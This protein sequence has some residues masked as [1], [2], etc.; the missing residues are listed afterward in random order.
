MYVCMY[1]CMYGNFSTA[2]RH[3]PE[4][5]ACLISLALWIAI[6]LLLQV[7]RFWPSNTLCLQWDM[8]CPTVSRLPLA[9][10][11]VDII[12]IY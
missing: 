4:N 1:V 8:T 5:K 9:V 7:T 10:Q 11:P 2:V 6:V 3:G 12:F